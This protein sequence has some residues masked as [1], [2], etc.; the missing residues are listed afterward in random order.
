MKEQLFDLIVR[1]S[2][3]PRGCF[4]KYHLTMDDSREVTIVKFH[5]SLY[6]VRDGASGFNGELSSLISY[7]EA[8]V[9]KISEIRYSAA[10]PYND[11]EK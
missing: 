8:N 5:N 4:R 10:G 6:A 2:Q 3:E 1:V 7:L 9:T 11:G